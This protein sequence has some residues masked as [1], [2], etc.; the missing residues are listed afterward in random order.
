M[1]NLTRALLRLVDQ[2]LHELQKENYDV[3][4]LVVLDVCAL[5]QEFCVELVG[6]YFTEF[7]EIL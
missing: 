6:F 1:L 3:L 5:E 7:Y 2:S 4:D